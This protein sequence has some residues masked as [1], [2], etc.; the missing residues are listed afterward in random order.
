MSDATDDNETIGSSFSDERLAAIHDVDVDIYAVLGR[1]T[2]LVSQ[3]L[4]V[5]RGAIIELDQKT[6]DPIEIL[7]N[8]EL[9]AKGEIVTVDD[10]LGITISEIVKKTTS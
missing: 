4:K 9:V 7:V 5:G 6:S 8:Q 3:L 10:N 1:S 2:M